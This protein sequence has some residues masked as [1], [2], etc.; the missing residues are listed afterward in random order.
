[1]TGATIESEAPTGQI[2]LVVDDDKTLLHTIEAIL[3]RNDYSLIAACS[4]L[5]ALK[6]SGDFSGDIHLLLTDVVMPEMDGFTLAGADSRRLLKLSMSA[7]ARLNMD[8][9]KNLPAIRASAFAI[10][11]GGHPIC[12]SNSMKV[13]GRPR[14]LSQYCRPRCG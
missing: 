5:E 3:R 8:L 9:P 13:A 1:M 2:V 6:K 10:S 4:P 12:C 11:G 14:R 7:Y